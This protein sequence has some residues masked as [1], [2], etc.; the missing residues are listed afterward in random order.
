[1]ESFE[2]T[3]D[4]LLVAWI[5]SDAII[6]NGKTTQGTLV[7]RGNVYPGWLVGA[8]LQCVC[9]EILK[10]LVQMRFA[11]EDIRQSA[12]RHCGAALAQRFSEA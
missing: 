11:N 1:M 12:I 4:F 6:P 3:K 8:V 10:H 9:D 5:D 7:G 2:N